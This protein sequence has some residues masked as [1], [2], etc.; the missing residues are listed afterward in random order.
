MSF[1]FEKDSQISD[2]GQKLS[3]SNACFAFYAIDY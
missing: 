3:T 1:I 2:C